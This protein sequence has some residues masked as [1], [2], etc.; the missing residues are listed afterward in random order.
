MIPS[1]KSS[2]PTLM[3]PYPFSLKLCSLTLKASPPP[4][5]VDTLELKRRYHELQ[6][7][8]MAQ[9]KQANEGEAGRAAPYMSTI[10]TQEQVI[11]NL[12]KLLA[13]V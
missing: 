13:Q 3:F 8:H 9:A 2:C 4:S 12:E 10:K 7:A 1:D 5:Q 11:G 6:T